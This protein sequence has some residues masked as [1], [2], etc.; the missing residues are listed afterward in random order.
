MGAGSSGRSF[1]LRES[2]PVNEI[3]K[4]PTS[5]TKQSRQGKIANSDNRN[6]HNNHRTAPPGMNMQHTHSE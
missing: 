4:T 6:N 1:L 5:F 3:T 2:L